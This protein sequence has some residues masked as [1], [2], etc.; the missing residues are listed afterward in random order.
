MVPGYSKLVEV[1]ATAADSSFA[2]WNWNASSGAD[3]AEIESAV[4]KGGIDRFRR[5][6]TGKFLV[7]VVAVGIEFPH[8]VAVDEVEVVILAG[9]GGELPGRARRILHVGQHNGPA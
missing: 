4:E 6:G 2:F 5:E 7:N 1:C 3:W 8:G 9:S